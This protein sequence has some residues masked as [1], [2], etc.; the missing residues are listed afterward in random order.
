MMI[1]LAAWGRGGGGYAVGGAAGP[2]VINV[3]TGVSGGGCR[4]RGKKGW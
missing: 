4:R 2:P 1:M 3:D